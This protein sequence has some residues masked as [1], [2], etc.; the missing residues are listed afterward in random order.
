MDT[1]S[2]YIFL[3]L[4]LAQAAHSIEEYAFGLYNVF[5]PARL[6]SGLFGADLARGFLI[7]NAAL[8]LFGLWCYTARVRAGHRS[9]VA[10]AWFWACLECGN[11]IS[12]P[13]V[14]LTRGAYFP[15]VATAPV[16][17]S[18]SVYLGARLWRVGRRRE[19]AV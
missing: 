13:V 3:A 16:L 7:A 8:L 12:H 11:G 4:I 9:G 10:W 19:A 1:R 5:A 14:A 2:Q 18:L 15:G 17:L 6:I